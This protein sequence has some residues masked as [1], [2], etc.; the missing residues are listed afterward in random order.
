MLQRVARIRFGRALP[1]LVIPLL[2][3]GLSSRWLALVT[4]VN[5]QTG[6]NLIDSMTNE[7]VVTDESIK[8]LVP[9]PL[10]GYDDAVR[11]ALADRA[12]ARLNR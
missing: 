9:G 3:P 2:T 7:V 6:R 10:L 5:V 1:M 11:E 8:D 12:K 4:D